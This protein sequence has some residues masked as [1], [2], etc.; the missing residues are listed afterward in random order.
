MDASEKLS[1]ARGGEVLQEY[2]IQ[3]P[4]SERKST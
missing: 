2:L 4:G 3:V 1:A